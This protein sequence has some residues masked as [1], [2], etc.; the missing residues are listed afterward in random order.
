M[1]PEK[2]VTNNSKSD[3][4]GALSEQPAGEDQLTRRTAIFGLI[5]LIVGGVAAW[6]V[7]TAVSNTRG[8]ENVTLSARQ[9]RTYTVKLL[10][11]SRQKRGQAESMLDHE[12]LLSLAGGHDLLLESVG[13]ETIAVCAGQFESPDSLEA[14]Q[15][16]ERVASYTRN[17]KP[18]FPSAEILACS[19]ERS[20]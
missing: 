19:P 6:F 20:H 17:E 13:P 11:M 7:L 2:Q 14:R 18:A 8:T 15:L 4:I 3:S 16:L 9:N 10:S 12:V 1:P 5:V